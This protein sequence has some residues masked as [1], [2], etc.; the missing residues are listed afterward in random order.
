MSGP[1]AVVKTS[2]TITKLDSAQALKIEHENFTATLPSVVVSDAVQNV[3]ESKSCSATPSKNA[4]H[5]VAQEKVS[6]GFATSQLPNAETPAI[7]KSET[8]SGQPPERP[9]RHASSSGESHGIYLRSPALMISCWIFGVIFSLCHHL[10][11]SHFD[12]SIV[13]S[14]DEQQWNIRCVSFDLSISLDKN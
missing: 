9:T 10:F 6:T 3:G 11:Y 8:D 13:G 7:E 1:E 5:E 12:G 2:S 14:P 4:E